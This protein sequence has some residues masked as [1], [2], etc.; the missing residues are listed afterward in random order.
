MIYVLEPKWHSRR[1]LLA[2]TYNLNIIQ[3]FIKVLIKEGENMITSLNNSGNAVI[4]DLVPLLNEYML[5]AVIEIGVGTSLR[6]LG[7]FQQQYREALERMHEPFISRFWKPWLYINWMF[8][9]TSEGREYRKIV[10]MF[11]KFTDLAIIKRKFYHDCTNDKYLPNFDNDR[12]TKEDSSKSIGYNAKLQK[13]QFAMLD[14]LI[15]ESRKGHMI[16]SDIKEE[17]NTFIF[18]SYNTTMNSMCFTLALLAEHR[19][20]Q[21][22]V[23]NEIRTALQNNGNKFTVELLQDLTYLERCIKESLRLYPTNFM[24][25]RI[26]EKDL[27]LNLFLIPAGTN[28]CF[29]IYA[30]H[31]NCYFW[32]NP[33]VFDPD[34]FLPEMIQNRHPYSY[35]PF[36][37]GPRNCIGQEFAMLKMKAIIALVIQH[38]YLEPIDY[39]K[40]VRL[41]VNFILRPSSSLRVKFT[42]ICKTNASS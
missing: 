31:R 30:T 18:M 13:N 25:S 3:Q 29:N 22:R 19:D 42:P 28:V 39:L 23:R 33:E 35:L 34:R 37:A 11:E 1:K 15:A 16:D 40:D 6:D 20:I 21:I 41:N 7:M 38:F 2:H 10:K 32:P 12:S 27:K 17:I 8:F 14:L 26:I 4:K 24:I 5:N 9:L 36:C